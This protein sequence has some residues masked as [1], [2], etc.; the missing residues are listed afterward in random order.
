MSLSSS[1]VACCGARP[2]QRA[3]QGG[4]RRSGQWYASVCLSSARPPRRASAFDVWPNTWTGAGGDRV[5]QTWQLR[6]QTGHLGYLLLPLLPNALTPNAC[7]RM[8]ALIHTDSWENLKQGFD[9][10]TELTVF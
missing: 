4:R 7:I 1:D 3:F 5:P 6:H 8:H 9:V 10:L 2:R